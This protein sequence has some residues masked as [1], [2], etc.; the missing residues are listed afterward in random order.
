MGHDKVDAA[1][2]IRFFAGLPFGFRILDIS[3]NEVPLQFE[4]LTHDFFIY[5]GQLTFLPLIF[6]FFL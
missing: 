5:I 1:I 2:T 3:L 6:W 4:V